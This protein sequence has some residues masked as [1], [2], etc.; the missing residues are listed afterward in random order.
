MLCP[1][2]DGL[3]RVARHAAELSAW[4][5]P[6]ALA[7]AAGRDILIPVT[8]QPGAHAA[9]A[10]PGEADGF[11]RAVPEG[12][13]WRNEISPAIFLTVG[14]IRPVARPRR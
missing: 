13:P 10:L 4:I 9:M 11:A 7:D 14:T 1:F 3:R 5:I 8:G 2:V 6:R 12:S